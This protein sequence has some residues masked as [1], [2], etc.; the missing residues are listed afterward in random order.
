MNEP[1]TMMIDEVKYIRA[2]QAE[3]VPTKKQI[4]VLQR[5]WV[6]VGDVAKNADEVT[7]SNCSIVRIWGT[8]NGLGEIAEN[9]AT[10]KTKL[11]KCPDIVVHPLSVVLYMNVNMDKW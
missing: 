8:S 1:K 9:G 7:V 4:I 10:S 3:V 5:G 6:V 11:D 2:D